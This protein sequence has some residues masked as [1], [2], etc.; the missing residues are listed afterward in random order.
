MMALH[1]TL[2]ALSLFLGLAVH[3]ASYKGPSI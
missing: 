3:H 2:I 1:I